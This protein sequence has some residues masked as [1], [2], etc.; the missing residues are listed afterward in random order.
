[1]FPQHCILPT[2]T[3]EQ[4]TNEVYSELFESVQKLAKPAKKKFLKK[5]AKAL[6]CLSNPTADQR[7]ELDTSEGA[8]Q[9]QQEAPPVTTTTNPTDP[10]TLQT[11]P[12]THARMTRS[13]EPGRLPVIVNDE[14]HQLKQR[15]SR[16]LANLDEEPIITINKPSSDRIPLHSP[17]II[18]FSAVNQVT[19]QVYYKDHKRWAPSAFLTSSPNRQY[20]DYDCDIEH[21]CAGVTHPVTGEMI[22][23]YKN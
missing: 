4:H 20:A 15:R 8:T 10:R 1:M 9:P 18:A 3:P 17:N 16:R 23:K 5:I 14:H 12:R 13:N 2:F 19:E 21:M 7:V 6:E 22:T 11:K